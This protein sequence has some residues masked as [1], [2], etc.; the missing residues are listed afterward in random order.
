MCPSVQFPSPSG[1][2]RWH[3]AG[4][5]LV[6]LIIA[7]AV[8]SVGLLALTGAGAAIVRLERRGDHLS[9]I[10]AAGETRLEL[11]RAQGCAAESG[12]SEAGPIVEHWTV[13]PLAGG[14]HTLVDSVIEGGPASAAVTRPNVYR[15]AA[16]C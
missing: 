1:S 4:F 3:R 9:H 7:T 12:T 5:T 11:L 8:L 2:P 16:R 13:L 10:A 15:S 6:E 14:V